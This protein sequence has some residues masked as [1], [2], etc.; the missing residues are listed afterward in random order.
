[1]IVVKEF[2]NKEFATK[3]ELFAELK[4]NKSVFIAQKKAEIYKSGEKGQAITVKSDAIKKLSDTNKEIKFD[5]N[6]YYFAVNS[7]NFLDSH[8]DM[9]IDGNWNKTV[10][11]QQGQVYLV[12]DH[13]LKRGDIIAMRE[14][15]EMFTAQVPWSLLGKNYSGETYT[16]IYKVAK[17]KIINAEAKDWLEKGYSLQASVR[18][19]YM[20]IDLAMKSDKLEDKKERENYDKYEPLIANKDDFPDGVSYFW[21]VKQAKNVMESSWLLFGSNSATGVIQE[22]KSEA[23]DDTTEKQTEPS[24]DTQ[25]FEQLKSIINKI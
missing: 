4:A 19:Q 14:D 7:A 24:I 2:P 9:H 15:I 13:S 8:S 3:E 21:I 22:N 6:Y 25:A 23:V 12:F 17:D 16:L 10:K 11:E 18:M 1:M 5:D 20:D